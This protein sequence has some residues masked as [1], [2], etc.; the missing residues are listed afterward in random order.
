MGL[1]GCGSASVAAM[2]SLEGYP[3]AQLVPTRWNDNDVYGHVNN[4]V[5][6]LAMDT[7]INAWM[8]EHAGLDIAAGAAVG[9]CVESGCRY[10]AA[11]TYPDA[12]VL[13]LRISR[14]GTSSVHWQVAMNRESDGERIA[15]G[16]FVHVFVERTTRR[17]TSL[18]ST[19]RVA[20]EPL[21]V[22]AGVD[23]LPAIDRSR[24][25]GQD[26]ER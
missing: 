24:R 10:L 14:L 13:G 21:V 16:T 25:L 2:I 7:V 1:A 17:P 8:I 26:I 4:T 20:M 11:V 19:M 15:E 18:T 3:Y 23:P 9:L 12:M 22:P 6:H 5:H